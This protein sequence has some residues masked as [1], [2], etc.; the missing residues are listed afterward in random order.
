[1]RQMY[2]EGTPIK[3]LPRSFRNLTK[4][5]RLRM[6][7]WVMPKEN[8]VEQKVC[9]SN[10]QRNCKLTEEFFLVVATWFVT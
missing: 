5:K 7:R 1:M 10:V 9:T 6:S 4:L 8:E 3:K 2:L